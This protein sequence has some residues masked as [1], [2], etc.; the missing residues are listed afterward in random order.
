MLNVLLPSL[1]ERPD[2]IPALLFHFARQIIRDDLKARRQADAMS[3]LVQ[4]YDWPGNIR[5]LQNFV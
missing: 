1:R 5:E 3:A 4:G 2:D